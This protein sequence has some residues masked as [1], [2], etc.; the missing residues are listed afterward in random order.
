MLVVNKPLSFGCMFVLSCSGNL[1]QSY[2]TLL[3]AS[4]CWLS[5]SCAGWLPCGY[6]GWSLPEHAV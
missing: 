6:A 5:Y 3:P 1:N 4:L 2:S